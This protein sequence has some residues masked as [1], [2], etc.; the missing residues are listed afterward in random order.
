MPSRIDDMPVERDCDDLPR[1]ELAACLKRLLRGQFKTSAARNLHADDG[2]GLDVV[3]ADDF[4]QLLRVVHGVKLGASDNRH[5]AAHE[6]A[7]ERG[8]CVGR[9]V[10]G[11]EK[12]R[13]L[14]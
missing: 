12:L 8:V 10:G 3:L 1:D 14:E 11:D 7:M 4:R 2:H 13:A 9:A 5:L 6:V